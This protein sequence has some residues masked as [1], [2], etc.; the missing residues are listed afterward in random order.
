MAFAAQQYQ[1]LTGR[2]VDRLTA[3]DPAK[4]CFIDGVRNDSLPNDIAQFVDVIHTNPGL[5]GEDS[6]VGHADFYPGGEDPVQNGCLFFE[7]SHSRAVEYFA[8]SVYPD[9]EQDFLASKCDSMKNMHDKT[10]NFSHTVMGYEVDK[11]ASGIYYLEVNSNL[12]FGK[13]SI[14]DSVDANKECKCRG[15]MC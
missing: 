6:P 2:L 13:N 8:E 1:N 12:P 5:L 11:N 10:C 15:V 4:P 14:V 9:Q 7:C 3:L